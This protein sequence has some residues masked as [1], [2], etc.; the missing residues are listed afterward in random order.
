MIDSCEYKLFFEALR[1]EYGFGVEKNLNLALSIYIKSS[2][3]NSKN[4]LSMGRLYDIYKSDNEKFKIE[5]DKNL[6]MIYLLKCFTYFPIHFF[7]HSSNI[8]FPLNPYSAL[9]IFLKNNFL[10][11]KDI[12]KKILL[13]IDELFKLKEYNNTIIS[14]SDCNLMKGFIDGFL[15]YF[16]IEEERNSYD[17]L[18]AMSYDGSNEATYKLV[19]IYLNKLKKM[20]EKEKENKKNNKNKSKSDKK[21]EKEKLMIKIFDLF[22]ILEKNKYYCSYA[23]YGIFLY[24]EMRMFDKA[25]EIF[26]EGYEHN[27]YNCALYYFHSYTKSENLTIYDTNKFDSTKFINIIQPLIDSFIIGEVISLLNLF[28]FIYIIGK[29]YNL[30]SQINNKYMKYLNEI[31]VLCLKFTNEKI[32]EDYCKKFSPMEIELLKESSYKS[33]SY[34]YMHGLTTKVKKNLLKVKKCLINTMKF[35]ERSEPYY[36]RLLYKLYKKLFNLG[37]FEDKEEL[38]K[39]ENK[40]FQLYEKNKNYENYGNSYYYYFGKIY[41]KGI[42][43]KKDDKMAY[44]FYLKGIKPLN[45]L[46]DCFIIVYAKYLSLKIVNS[47][48]FQKYNPNENN[49]KKYNVIFRL[50]FGE[51]NINLLVNDNM[52]INDIKN[53]LYKKPELQNLR[54]KCFLFNATILEK[55]D[56]IEKYK[57]KE[58]DLILVMVDDK[59]EVN[60]IQ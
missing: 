26:R 42:G 57:V 54:I 60:S 58:N 12:S 52:T 8:R 24:D 36:T 10:K 21:K 31:A 17:I 47:K 49:L 48:K 20:K 35:R 19:G 28:D 53:E 5:K 37:V 2:G 1:Y 14:Q 32:E 40:V 38:T 27:Q 11:V 15:G 43:V 13:Y 18:T 7:I 30:F 39:L 16:N 22:Q 9:I 41:E 46:L 34:I 29:K 45:N 51:K 3:V 44:S 50:S 59:E 6:E 55:E 4:Y 23:S 33:L 25:L 56:K